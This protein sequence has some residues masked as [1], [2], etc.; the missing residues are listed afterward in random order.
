MECIT[1]LFITDGNDVSN[2][3][4][5]NRSITN[6]SQKPEVI[7]IV[8]YSAAYLISLFSILA[9][10][11]LINGLKKTNKKLMMSQKLYISLSISDGIFALILPYH[12]TLDMLTLSTC[13]TVSIGLCMSVYTLITSFGTFVIISEIWPLG[14]CFILSPKHKV[15]FT[16]AFWN[17]L[18]ALM[19]IKTFFTHE[20][21]SSQKL[22]PTHWLFTGLWTTFLFTSAKRPLNS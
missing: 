10:I 7:V 20:P 13:T 17:L 5:N 14:N 16:L 6:P 19:G 8:T 4:T 1:D 9:N 18:A 21:C 11:G 3:I 15:Y 2:N 12:A 22:H